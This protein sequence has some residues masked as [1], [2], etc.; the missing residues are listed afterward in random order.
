MFRAVIFDFDGVITDSEILHFRSF[1]QVLAPYN[2]KVTQKEYYTRFLGLSDMEVFTMY[3]EQGLIDLQGGQI[4]DIVNN[5]NR[6]FTEL[7][8]IEGRIIEGVR[9]ILN[10]L[11]DNNILIAIYSGSLLSEI[12]LILAD[13]RLRDFFMTIVSAEQVEKGKPHP[14]GF[15]LALKRLNKLTSRPIL[16]GECIVIEDSVWGLKS[17]IA[18]DMHTIAITNSYQAHELD[19]AEK[20]VAHMDELTI[21]DLRELCG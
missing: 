2:I 21:E 19:I 8:K 6:V 5:K 17:A 16:P 20:V 14:D 13:A 1:N 3:V 10:M 12:E 11:R 4:Q 18:A 9:G 7:I 15:L